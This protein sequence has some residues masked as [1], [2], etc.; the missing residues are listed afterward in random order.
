MQ[1][2]DGDAPGLSRRAFIKGGTGIVSAVAVA[3]ALPGCE[4][5]VDAGGVAAPPLSVGRAAPP[6]PV[7]DI[8]LDINGE[9][10]SFTVEARTTLA[11]A[12]RDQL[13]LTGTKIG[14]DRA[15]C[16]ACTVLVGGRSTLSCSILAVE[17]VGEPV[18][19]IEGLAV[20]GVLHPIQA[21]FVANDAL[22]CG[23]CTPGMVMS[24]KALLDKNPLP[25]L[26]QVK[27]GVAG[28]LC[29][30]GTYPRV[31]QACLDASGA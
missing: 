31:F 23:F 15:A 25:N 7:L 28:N 27:D 30:C 6:A 1:E 26:Q 11:E 17:A 10:R 14:C 8:E 22:Q 4:V 2:Q 24:C 19:T 18:E 9:A 21:A 3:Q 20:D 13:G 12:L 29:R 16:G 5:P